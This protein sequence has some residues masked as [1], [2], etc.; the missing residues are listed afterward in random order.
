M[1]ANISL[2]VAFLAGLVSFLSPCMIAIVPGFLAYLAGASLKEAD[3]KRKEIFINSIFFVLGF[4][5][6]F[7]ILGVLLNTLLSNIAYDVQVWLARV[8]GVIIIAF[9]L[10]L[11]KLIKIGWLEKEHKFK[12]PI[13]ANRYATSFLFGM[14][15][16]AG[17]TPCVGVALGAI[18]GL[19]ATEPASAFILLMTYSLGL[20]LP[21]LLVGLFASQVHGV[22]LKYARYLEWVNIIFGLV[23]VGIGTLVFMQNLQILADTELIQSMF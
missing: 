8:G 7:A 3:Q 20:G 6:V 19:A 2:E 9:G 11:M 12:V 15:L 13:L 5:L 10:Y 1:L 17:W 14:S 16:A 21:F 18:L 4:A 23:L 22:I